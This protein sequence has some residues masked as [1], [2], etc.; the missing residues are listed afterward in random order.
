MV[1]KLIEKTAPAV[2]LAAPPPT[3]GER[4][5]ARILDVAYDAIVHK[6][7]AATSIDELVEAAGITKS[8]F[9]YH[10]KDKNDLARQLLERFLAE[11]S[12]I[13]DTLE[14]RARALADDPLQSF[15]IFLNLYAEMMDEMPELHPG[16][17]VAMIT[18]QEQMF[19]RAVRE[20]NA[21]SVIGMRL[22]F[23]RWL[24][25]IVAKHPPRTPIDINAMADNVTV[26]VEGAIILSKAM[27][28]RGLM[29]RHTRL[30]RDHVKLVFGAS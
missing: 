13:L 12:E 3:K 11:D 30:F 2:Q 7:F 25:E 10:F 29:G 8:G 28:D 9:F 22:R 18:Y 1:E 21:E 26:I 14:A 19:D 20:M 24:E 5:R 23:A 27:N 4:T 15:L 16:C 17:L 6:G